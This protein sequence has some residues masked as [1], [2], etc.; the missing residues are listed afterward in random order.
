M[1]ILPTLSKIYERCMYYKMYKYFDQILS[2]YQCSFRQGYNTQQY[3]LM[4]I[5]KWKETFDKGGLGGALLTDQSKAFDCIKH[6]LLI[7]KLAVYGFNSRSL[8]FVFSY[9]M[10]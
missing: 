6:N 3:L 9:L 4:M 5:A 10:R 1:C 8:R 7:A 2:K